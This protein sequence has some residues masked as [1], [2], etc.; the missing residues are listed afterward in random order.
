MPEGIRVFRSLFFLALLFVPLFSLTGCGKKGWPTLKEYEKPLQPT[1]FRAIH[2]EQSI[3]FYWNYPREKEYM[4]AD[5]TI[6]KASGAEVETLAFIDNS[7]R[8]H[9]DTA[10]ENRTDYSYKIIARSTTGVSSDESNVLRISPLPPPH[11]PSELSFTVQDDSLLL[12]WSSEE[13]NVLY[14]VYKSL[15]KGK[16]AMLPINSSPISDTHFADSLPDNA[17]VYYTVRSL[18]GGALRDESAP[19]QECVIEP[20]RFV[21]QPPKNFKYHA[22]PDM[23]FLYWDEP[24]ESWVTRFRIYRKTSGEEFQLIG[25]TML[26]VFVDQ[27]PALTARDY[28]LQA[29]GPAKEGPGSEITGVIYTAPPE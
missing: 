15:E 1:D 14:N 9:E 6:F 8:S 16:Y 17:T 4:I 24:K 10:V 22:A 7:K 25:E 26:P 2:R 11:P 28:R 19:S 13:N 23:V 5:F 21:P 27:E 3:F 29:V 20:S 12:S 18:Y